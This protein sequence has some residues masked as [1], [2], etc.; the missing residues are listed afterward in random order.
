[1]YKKLSLGPRGKSLAPWEDQAV[2]IKIV[3]SRS[4]ATP[5]EDTGDIAE[6]LFILKMTS[7]GRVGGERTKFSTMTALK[8]PYRRSGPDRSGGKIRK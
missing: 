3:G 4:S 8:P 1:M 2:A 5:P 6:S 7:G